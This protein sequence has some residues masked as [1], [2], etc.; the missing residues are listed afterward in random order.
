M[1]PAWADLHND[2]CV[3]YNWFQVGCSK[4]FTSGHCWGER[5]SHREQA[6]RS[7]PVPQTSSHISWVRLTVSVSWG[8]EGSLTT[9]AFIPAHSWSF[10]SLRL[11]PLISHCICP[12]NTQDILSHKFLRD[13]KSLLYSWEFGWYVSS[14]VF[15]DRSFSLWNIFVREIY[16]LG[17]LVCKASYILPVLKILLLALHAFNP[18]YIMHFL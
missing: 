9:R 15:T 14:T 2:I 13:S 4:S 11:P 7:A 8:R 3:A 18:F 16:Y 6:L 12:W 1:F 10:S 17:D 5:Q